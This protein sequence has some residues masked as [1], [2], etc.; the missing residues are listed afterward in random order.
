A[1]RERRPRLAGLRGRG[2]ARAPLP[3]APLRR[4]GDAQ[5]RLREP[6]VHARGP[7]AQPRG[8]RR[9]R[10]RGSRRHEAMTDR[11]V[12]VVLPVHNQADHI[13]TVV[14]EYLE[15][16]DRLGTPYEIVLVPNA[17]RDATPEVCKALAAGNP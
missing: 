2:R 17:C 7:R 14:R 6:A 4:P 8:P 9:D 15:P 3:R 10:A 5:W 11:L 16:L 12:S 1:L 13:D